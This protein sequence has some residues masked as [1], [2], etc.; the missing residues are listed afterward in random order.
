MPLVKQSVD[1]PLIGG[2][3]QAIDAFLTQ[4]GQA[5]D[6]DNARITTEGG[7]PKRHGT[8]TIGG[9]TTDPTAT[10]LQSVVRLGSWHSSPVAVD[11]N[12]S[13]GVQ[14]FYSYNA[15]LGW[16]KS[17]TGAPRPTIRHYGMGLGLGTTVTGL[18]Q[19]YD[20]TSDT[21][22]VVWQDTSFI[23]HAVLDAKSGGLAYPVQTITAY[24]DAA[25]RLT[26]LGNGTFV[27]TYSQ[28][29]GTLM[30]ARAKLTATSNFGTAVD[31]SG[32]AALTASNGAHDAC[33]LQGTND[34]LILAYPRVAAGNLI[35]IERITVTGTV[36]A[37]SAS[38][39]IAIGATAAIQVDGIGIRAISGEQIWLVYC[40][41]NGGGN[42]QMYGAVANASTC[43][44]S[45]SNSVIGGLTSGYMYQRIG[46]ERIDGTAC[47]FAASGGSA[48]SSMIR[49]GRMSL[50]GTS[51]LNPD[52]WRCSLASRPILQGTLMHCWLVGQT[53]SSALQPADAL[54]CQ[55]PVPIDYVTAT[56]LMPRVVG[57]GPQRQLDSSATST[58]NG[59]RVAN[60]SAGWG[61]SLLTLVPVV[62]EL[63]SPASAPQIVFA[64]FAD[65]TRNRGIQFADSYSMAPGLSYDGE[66]LAEFGFWQQPTFGPIGTVPAS[67]LLSVGTYGV[68]C[69][70]RWVDSRGRIARAWSSASTV[71]T[72]VNPLDKIVLYVAALQLTDR[73]D[74]DSPGGTFAGLRAATLEV[75]R[76][77]V[78]GAVFYLD[79]TATN[80]E[81]IALGQTQFN[82]TQ[83]DSTLITRATFPGTGLARPV[84]PPSLR[85]LTAWHGRLVGIGPDLRTVW[86]SSEPADTDMP[87]WN[88]A[89]NVDIQ[90]AQDLTGLAVLDDKLLAFSARRCWLIAGSPA[91]ASGSGSSLQVQLISSDVGA[92][93]ERGIV[94]CSLGVFFQGADQLY[95]M[96][97]SLAIQPVGLAV[98]TILAQYPIIT[99]ALVVDTARE[100]RFTLKA[101]ETSTT[102]VS[103]IYHV[104]QQRWSTR[105]HYFDVLTGANVGYQSATVVDGVWYGC[106]R[107]VGSITKESSTVYTDAATWV[108]TAVTTPWL[109]MAG[110]QG[111]QRVQRL[112]ILLRPQTAA[113]VRVDL[114]ADY[115]AAPFY[116]NTFDAATVA[117]GRLAIHVPRQ[118]CE[119][120]KV[121]MT[122]LAD[123]VIGT[124]QGVEFIA[125]R[126]QVGIKPAQSKLVPQYRKH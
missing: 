29:L 110:V 31:V 91:D 115:E 74:A 69:C 101:T 77:A 79:Q 14:D 126:M 39:A 64:D 72:S 66:R 19:L 32:A 52:L 78:N 41:T 75:Y 12:A 54:L 65:E 90:D 13:T 61:T 50:A 25:P 37:V 67:G 9:A 8:T 58:L 18:D 81:T 63:I 57:A 42:S 122:D 55:M 95:L 73:Q 38:S 7:F 27:L 86:I 23:Y 26:R 111:F 68:Q 113:T 104:T 85:G 103:L 3:N 22:T 120:L 10:A 84:S 33:V 6:V 59:T 15:N 117:T 118:K 121:A 83:A 56:V 36:P 62:R 47:Y 35:Q 114:Y 2:V 45:V 11:D 88:E 46:I 20:A 89:F 24:G 105:H 106:V 70:Y 28:A 43:V 124:G 109:K 34:Q 102:G 49:S 96:D 93:D 80:Y 60:T 17:T 116:S 107:T 48:Q 16:T 40:A 4:P 71:P 97:R 21:V 44:P 125:L 108:S 112:Q 30:Y 53:A 51:M 87:V 99:S 94:S 100:I 98:Q 1:I 119:A 123:A 5:L 82:L 76:T 92:K